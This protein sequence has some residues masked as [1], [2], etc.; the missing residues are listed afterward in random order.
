MCQPESNNLLGYASC[1][2]LQL[3][4]HSV[5]QVVG[6]SKLCAYFT[7]YLYGG[8]KRPLEIDHRI[9]M[10]LA[11]P[12]NLQHTVTQRLAAHCVLQVVGSNNLH[13]QASSWI[14]VDTF[15]LL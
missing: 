14:Q 9:S 3:A 11:E 15:T 8:A 13:T 6:F 4:A 1:W 5:L 7:I 2:I 12:N 10:Q